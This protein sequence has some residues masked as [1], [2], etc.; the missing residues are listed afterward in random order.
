MQQ[1]V[2][3]YDLNDRSDERRHEILS[4]RNRSIHDRLTRHDRR[5]WSIDITMGHRAVY[6]L[7]FNALRRLKGHGIYL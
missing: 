4:P 1:T 6:A 2:A 7:V 5:G 3:H